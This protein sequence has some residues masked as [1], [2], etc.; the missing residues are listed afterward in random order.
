MHVN[1]FLHENA[2]PA[3]TEAASP[4]PLVHM[5]SAQVHNKWCYVLVGHYYYKGITEQ[6]SILLVST[7]NSRI[8][9]PMSHNLQYAAAEDQRLQ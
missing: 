8:W 4:G 5:F 7:K 3:L 1:Q 9:E 2:H 6:V